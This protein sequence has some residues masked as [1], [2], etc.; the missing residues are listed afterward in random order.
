MN[1]RDFLQA[2]G[3]AALATA[4]TS[5]AALH[6]AEPDALIIDTHQHLWDRRQLSLPWLDD[7]PEILRHNY[8]TPLY[9][10]AFAGYNV[11]SIYMEVDVAPSNH[12]KEADLIV[13]LCRKGRS[14][15]I[16]AT[17]GGRPASPGFEAYVK[18]YAGDGVVKG[19]RQCLH[20]DTT[21]RGI[22]LKPEFVKGVQTLGAHGLNFE[23]TIRPTE[24]MDGVKL[25]ELCP[26]THFVLDHCGNGDPKTF[27]P[28]LGP[29][30]KRNGTADGWKRGIDAFAKRPN[31][32]CKISGILAAVPLNKWQP[33]DLAPV[34]NHCLDAFGPRRVV[35]GGDWP[36]CL[37][38]G[39]VNEWIEAL[40]QIIAHRPAD[41]RRRLWSGNAIKHYRLSV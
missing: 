17:I 32:I 20:G 37:L 8:T 6:P 28:K 3:S 24:L 1:R 29:D 10:K 40:K 35:F 5:C 36:V 41:E 19:L 27:N 25:T 12:I 15:T 22:C 9:Q 13:D 33:S 21:P 38:G 16:A 2:T 14:T 31:V 39:K 23:I 18:R 7:A 11:K 26:D 4:A 34:V 30:M